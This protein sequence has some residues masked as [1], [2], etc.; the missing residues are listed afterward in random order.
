[1]RQPDEKAAWAVNDALAQAFEGAAGHKLRTK[2]VSTQQGRRCSGDLR[3]TFRQLAG[4]ERVNMWK[5]GG[6][7]G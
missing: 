1:M 6:K 3:A 7:E 4:R 5:P 2:V